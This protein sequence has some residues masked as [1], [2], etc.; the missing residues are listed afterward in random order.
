MEHKLTKDILLVAVIIFLSI[1]FILLGTFRFFF[2]EEICTKKA[3]KIVG[4]KWGDSFDAN[5][6]E[7]NNYPKFIQ[8]GK[9]YWGVR[10]K[11]KCEKEFKSF[12]L[13]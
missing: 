11:L 3:E 1:L 7:I 8:N 9:I 6:Y 4:T 2:Q 12:F 10:E 13:F 5:D